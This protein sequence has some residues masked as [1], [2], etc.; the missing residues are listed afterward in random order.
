[1]KTWN[2]IAYL[3]VVVGAMACATV[4]PGEG[5]AL[6]ARAIQLPHPPTEPAP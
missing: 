5:W 4:Q 1:M 2:S 6:E 3:A